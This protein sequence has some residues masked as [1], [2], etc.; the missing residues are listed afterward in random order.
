MIAAPLLLLLA[1]AA[2]GCSRQDTAPAHASG[3]QLF[4]ALCS[5]CHQAAANGRLF[6][7]QQADSPTAIADWIHHGNWLMPAFPNLSPDARKRLGDYVWAN[8]D[9]AGH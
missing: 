2:L 6:V 3:E 8:S 7:L 1:A 9:S 5:D 4:Q